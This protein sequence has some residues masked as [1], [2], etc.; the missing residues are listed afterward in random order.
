MRVD[1]SG[2]RG[3]D[4]YAVEAGVD[5]VKDDVRNEVR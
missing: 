1:G 5:C 2:R 3:R 4:V